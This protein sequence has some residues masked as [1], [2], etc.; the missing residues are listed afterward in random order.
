M[1]KVLILASALMVCAAA[2][3]Q[4]VQL[5]ARVGVFSQDMELRV[6]DIPELSGV[7]TDAKMGFHAAI[8][9]RIKLA[10]LGS[11]AVGM[12]FHLQP[13][14]VYSQNTYKIQTDPGTPAA[15]IKMQAIDIP[16][17]VSFKLSIIRAYVGPVFNVM[18]KTPSNKR[19]TDLMMIK[20]TVG[21]SVGLSVDI[22]GG[23][24]LDGRYNGQFKDLKNDL[25]AG[26]GVYQSVKGSL[27]SWAVGLSWLF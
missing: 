9:A 18:N 24:V 10:E 8:V 15:K 26:T 2:A 11:G 5:G 27:S 21:Y 1:K 25:D 14:V 16:V 19:E 3:A 13:E 12:G 4:R 7:E 22:F 17:L 6:T 20:P 23:L